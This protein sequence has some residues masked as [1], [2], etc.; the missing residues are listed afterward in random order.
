M[1][2]RNP[3]ADRWQYEIGGMTDSAAERRGLAREAQEAR[4]YPTRTCQVC[5]GTSFYRPGV[6]GWWCADRHLWKE[7]SV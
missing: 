6:G 2:T 3:W 4:E 5:G 7:V 1:T